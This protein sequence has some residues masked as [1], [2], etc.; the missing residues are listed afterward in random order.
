MEQTYGPTE[1][2]D[3]QNSQQRYIAQEKYKLWPQ[4][5]CMLSGLAAVIQTTRV[6]SNCL[7]VK[8]RR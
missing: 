7:P 4:A 3:S 5:A 6:C 2:V 8:F 1:L